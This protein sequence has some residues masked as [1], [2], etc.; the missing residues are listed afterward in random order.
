MANLGETQSILIQRVP[1]RNRK[2]RSGK[3][4]TFFILNILHP[5]IYHYIWTIVFWRI[6]CLRTMELRTLHI[7]VFL[8]LHIR[9]KHACVLLNKVDTVMS[10]FLLAPFLS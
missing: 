2:G 6:L 3:G 5:S 8:M 10:Q 7:F 1:H 9:K 4:M